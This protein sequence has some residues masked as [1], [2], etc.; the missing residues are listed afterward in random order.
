MP[1]RS[2]CK[3]RSTGSAHPGRRRPRPL[4]R[5]PPARRPLP[6]VPRARRPLPRVPRAR[7]QPSPRSGPLSRR[8]RPPPPACPSRASSGRS[9]FRRRIPLLPA[10]IR[11]GP[12]APDGGGRRPP[13]QRARPTTSTVSSTRCT[14]RRP[15]LRVADAGP[16]LEPRPPSAPPPRCPRS[17]PKARRRRSPTSRPNPRSRS[18]RRR[19]RLPRPPSLPDRSRSPP[20]REPSTPRPAGPR[21]FPGRPPGSRRRQSWQTPPTGDRVRCRRRRPTTRTRHRAVARPG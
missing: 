16:R 19:P 6:R 11:W 5:A 9:R 18:A 3:L 13:S 21:K 7:R 8:S 17:R 1:R 15:D 20:S 12:P 2:C 14:N 10:A 4:P